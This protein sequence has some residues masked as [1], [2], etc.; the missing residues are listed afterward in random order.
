MQSSLCMHEMN[1]HGL[2]GGVVEEVISSIRTVIAFEG[3]K[4]EVE[5]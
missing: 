4:K 5:R 3:Q 1:S 2:A